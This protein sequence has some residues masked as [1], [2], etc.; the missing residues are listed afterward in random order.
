MNTYLNFKLWLIYMKETYNACLITPP[1]SYYTSAQVS[2]FFFCDFFFFRTLS[3]KN[4][5]N[6]SGHNH[7]FVIQINLNRIHLTPLLLPTVL[8][9]LWRKLDFFLYA[10]IQT[11]SI[12][13]NSNEFQI[14]ST[15]L[16]LSLG[17]AFLYAGY[18]TD[19]FPNINKNMRSS[20][21]DTCISKD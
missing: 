15:Y 14:L 13:M 9:L 6:C 20:I 21:L 19:T 7:S 1:I 12:G 16:S 3:P 18:T 10:S 5:T 8:N 17:S 11:G 4:L 2:I